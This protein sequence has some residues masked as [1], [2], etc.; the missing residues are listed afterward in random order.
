MEC[1]RIILECKETVNIRVLRFSSHMFVKYK[2]TAFQSNVLSPSIA[3]IACE[4]LICCSISFAL[5]LGA[6]NLLC[7]TILGLSE[8]P[9]PSYVVKS[10]IFSYPPSPF[11][12][13]IDRQN[14]TSPYTLPLL[15]DKH[16]KPQKILETCFSNTKKKVFF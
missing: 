15:S 2:D 9:L 10:H 1:V 11:Y 13:V 14:F 4:G 3:K 8:P 7:N 6:V 12:G 5:I 16:Y